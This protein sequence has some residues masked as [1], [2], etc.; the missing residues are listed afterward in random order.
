MSRQLINHSPDLKKLGDEGYEIE[1]I[2]GHLVVRHIPYVNA[3]KEIDYGILVSEL[4]LTSADKTAKPG[5]HVIHFQGQ[6]PCDKDGKI[7]STIQHS[8]QKHNLGVEVHHSFSNKP[9]NGYNN[10]YEKIT[11]YI[12]IISASATALDPNVTAQTFKVIVDNDEGS[13]LQFVDTNSSRANLHEIN[14]KLEGQKIAI[15]GLGGTGAYILD[16][17]AKCRVGEIHL[18]DGDLYLLHNGFRSP[19]SPTKEILDKQLKKVHYYQSVYSNFHRHIIAHDYYITPENVD[20]LDGMT[21]VFIAVDEGSVKKPILTYLLESN[22]SFIDVGMGISKVDD[23]LIGILRVTTG[24]QEKNNHINDRISVSDGEDDE[25]NTNIQIA[26][27]NALNAALAVVKWKKLCGFYQD[28]EAEYHSTYS[29]NV[30]LLLNED[31]DV[32]A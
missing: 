16:F 31:K 30:G 22:V 4:S 25:Y 18:F 13:P 29:I 11:R 3:S 15:I 24:T 7:I 26:E 10:Y 20:E 17:V 21:Y 5:T 6:H 8:S 27:L 9:A 19:G 32:A 28:L 1:I 14:K 2:G 23:T 12:E